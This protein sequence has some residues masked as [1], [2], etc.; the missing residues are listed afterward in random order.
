MRELALNETL[1]VSGARK[2]D[3]L[4]AAG[5]LSLSAWAAT[6]KPT[7]IHEPTVVYEPY[8]Y[9]KTYV[10]PLYDAYGNHYGNKIDTYTYSGYEPVYIE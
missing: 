2:G 3:L 5:L 9:D 10:T 7:I 1:T 8:S 4:L 6:A